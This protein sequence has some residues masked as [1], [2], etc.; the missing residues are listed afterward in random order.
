V[1]KIGALDRFIDLDQHQLMSEIDGLEMQPDKLEIVFGQRRQES[2][3]R[4]GSRSHFCLPEGSV[5][6]AGSLQL[7]MYDIRRMD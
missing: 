6:A 2:I 1:R 7:R 5:A 4:T 3:G